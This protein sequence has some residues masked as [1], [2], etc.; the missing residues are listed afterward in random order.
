MKF[1][2]NKEE[3]EKINNFYIKFMNYYHQIGNNEI[4]SPLNAFN[5]LIW[6]SVG[7]GKNIFINQFIHE[8]I[9]SEGEKLWLK[10]T[11]Y[12]H[13]EY[14]IRIFDTLGFGDGNEIQLTK[15][16]IEKLE[17][18]IIGSNN[19]IYLILYFKKLEQINFF[20]FEI[21]L[22]KW[23]IEE[24]KNNFCCKWFKIS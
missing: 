7:V 19:Y 24:K 5:I 23:L 13:P 2:K 10:I 3:K 17:Q 6:G 8:K 22:I 12:L 11:N 21:D 20:K 18:N 15:K 4:N 9:A 16:S 1:P 14:P